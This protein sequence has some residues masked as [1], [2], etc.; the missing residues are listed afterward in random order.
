MLETQEAA[1]ATAKLEH[2]RIRRALST[3]R[4]DADFIEH[5]DD[6]LAQSLRTAAMT[7]SDAL[8]ALEL[9]AQPENDESVY[10]VEVK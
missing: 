2:A 10:L 3:I 6:E 7:I 4:R 1:P 5:G 8:F 9:E